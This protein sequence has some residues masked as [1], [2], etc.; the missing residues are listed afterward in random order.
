MNWTRKIQRNEL[1]WCGSKKKYKHCHL[2]KDNQIAVLD[3][4]GYIIPPRSL[5]KTP[6]EIEGIKKSCKLTKSILDELNTI[7]KPGIT[8]NEINN[9]VH[10]KTLD[11]NAIPAPLNYKGFPKS[12]CTSINEVVCH[13]IPSEY[14]LKEGDIINVDVTC[15]LDGYY[16]DSCRM[17]E[18][19][20]VND[21]AKKL[22][23][24]TKECLTISIE[25][26]KPYTSINVIG[27]TIHAHAKKHSYGVVHMF[28]GHGIG[29]RFHE[30]P[31]V[32]HCKRREKLMVM[33]PG[34]V[35]TIEPMINEGSADC[36]ILDDDWTAI[37]KDKK[38]SA[39]WEH[40][41]LITDDGAEILT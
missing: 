21:K 4:Q 11:N 27:D 8:T 28:G 16:G 2:K 19:G 35:F 23:D 41:I 14:V 30:E 13:G 5:I 17:Y 37:T 6:E 31:F 3:K 22:I 39:Q 36:I 38:L 12:I 25:N 9:W 40:T 15:I 18:V 7:I 32:Y 29:K 33:M 24:V 20:N 34:M 1:C 10:Q 26:I